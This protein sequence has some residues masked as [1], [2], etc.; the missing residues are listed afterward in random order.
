MVPGEPN[1]LKISGKYG[2]A[3]AAEVI[4]ASVAD[5]QAS[6]GDATMERRRG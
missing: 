1:K 6:F 3:H 2:Y 4:E 5:Y